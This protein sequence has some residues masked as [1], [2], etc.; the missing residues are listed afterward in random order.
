MC[1]CVVCVLVVRVCE[2]V[3]VSLIEPHRGTESRTRSGLD[4]LGACRKVHLTRWRATNNAGRER[5]E[6]LELSS[7]AGE[8]LALG[9]HST[10]HRG[11]TLCSKTLLPFTVSAAVV[12]GFAMVSRRHKTK[13]HARTGSAA[14]RAELRSSGAPV[15]PTFCVYTLQKGCVPHRDTPT[16]QTGR[17]DGERK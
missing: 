8:M 13:R 9:G 17:M 3:S 16:I 4:N 10:L 11:L 12:G 6:P 5:C 1:V 2:C 7:R 14:G 15:F